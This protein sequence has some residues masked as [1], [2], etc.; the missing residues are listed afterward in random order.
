MNRECDKMKERVLDLITGTLPEGKERA[1]RKH[2]GECSECSGYAEA[3]RNEDRMLT[4]L[5]TR[6]ETG[7]AGSEDEAIRRIGSVAGPRR[8]SLRWFGSDILKYSLTRHAA[9]AAVILVVALYFVIT[10]TWISQIQQY[11]ELSEEYIRA[12]M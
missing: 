4:G 11:I 6:L 2:M 12:A 9:A 10:L 3:L 8:R 7:L 5:F 1:V